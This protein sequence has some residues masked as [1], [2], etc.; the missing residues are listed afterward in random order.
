[1]T[2]LETDMMTRSNF[3][4]SEDTGRGARNLGMGVTS[5]SWQKKGNK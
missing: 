3:A 4:G 5:R 1:M 2:A